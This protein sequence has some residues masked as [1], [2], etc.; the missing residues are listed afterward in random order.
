MMIALQ[1]SRL[2]VVLVSPWVAKD[3][4]I[5]K[6]TRCA[7]GDTSGKSAR[8]FQ[9]VIFAFVTTRFQQG[10]DFQQIACDDRVRDQPDAY[11]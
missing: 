6:P 3:T 11:V 7:D 9:I 4:V 10:T 5:H 8:A 2:P 1:G